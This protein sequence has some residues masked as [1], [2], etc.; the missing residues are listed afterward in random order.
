MSG[1]PDYV[2]TSNEEKIFGNLKFTC[3]V[4]FE[5]FAAE[6]ADITVFKIE[7]S[8]F[9]IRSIPKANLKSSRVVSSVS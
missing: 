7:D 9:E 6:Q 4:D 5:A 3:K 8:T 1:V 2:F